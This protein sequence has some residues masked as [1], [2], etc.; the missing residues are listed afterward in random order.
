MPKTGVWVRPGVNNQSVVLCSWARYL[1]LAIQ[2]GE[3]TY[4][5]V[6]MGTG[7]PVFRESSN[8]FCHFLSSDRIGHKFV[9]RL[10]FLIFFFV[11]SLPPAPPPF[12]LSPSPLPPSVFSLHF[13][14]RTLV[15]SN[16]LNLAKNSVSFVLRFFRNT[17]HLYA[18]KDHHVLVRY[19]ATR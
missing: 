11:Y 10:T 4:L 8:T 2:R 16:D 15:L 18:D 13:L 14:S 7:Q 19:L 17:Q 3:S 12:P 6:Q 9:C 1:I 5:R